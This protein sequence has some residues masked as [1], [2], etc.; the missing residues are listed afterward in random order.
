MRI[1]GGPYDGCGLSLVGG[2]TAMGREATNDIVVEQPLVS[3]KHAMI[4]YRD[5]GFWIQDLG[6]QNGTYVDGQRV[7]QQ[8]R[9]LQDGERI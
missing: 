4:F 3:R 6:S 2:V 1:R 8:P 7:G 5:T 9:P